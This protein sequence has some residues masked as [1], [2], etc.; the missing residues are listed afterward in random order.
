MRVLGLDPGL[1][2]LGLGLIDVRA[3]NNISF[4]DVRVLRS[5]PGASL[6]D[7]LA[8][9]GSEIAEVLDTQEPDHIA[10]ERVFS[11]QNV[12]TVMGTAQIS[13]VV[14]YLAGLRNIPVSLYTPTQ[15]KAAVTGY[16]SADK[17]QVTAM[18]TR[19]L[20]LSTAPKP[21]DAAD[22]LALAITHAWQGGSGPV[23]NSLVDA[24]GTSVEQVSSAS[25]T[26]AQVA[27]RAAEQQSKRNARP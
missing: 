9:L 21:A 2:R 15:V 25:P 8:S 22:A 7:R 19:I 12:S 24:L 26:P 17:K 6:A 16:G 23:R 18:V 1:T 20:K 13:G 14:L 11:Q 5:S 27:W 10:L 4:H 3:R